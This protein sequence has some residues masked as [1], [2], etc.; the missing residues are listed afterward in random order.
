MP[1]PDHVAHCALGALTGACRPSVPA[2]AKTDGCYVRVTR[3]G[4]A[5][6][7][8]GTEYWLVHGELLLSNARRGSIDDAARPRG[9][10]ESEH[11]AHDEQLT[12]GY[13]ARDD[14]GI[15][16]V[17]ARARVAVDSEIWYSV[18]SNPQMS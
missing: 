16:C 3:L 12:A 15:D 17:G 4:I 11:N 7:L 9:C 2:W 10:G 13:G 8:L 6:F 14:G 5:K 18:R 1:R